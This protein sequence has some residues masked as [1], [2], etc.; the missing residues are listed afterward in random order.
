MPELRRQ[1]SLLPAYQKIN[2][3]SGNQMTFGVRQN[4]EYSA[5]SDKE[6]KPAGPF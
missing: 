1:G 3:L 6:K 4:I 5:G 2:R